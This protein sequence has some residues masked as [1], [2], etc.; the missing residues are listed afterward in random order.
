MD[1]GVAIAI[2]EYFTRLS[3]GGLVSGLQAR[4]G[5]DIG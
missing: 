5:D 3:F 4:P 2:T 1:A